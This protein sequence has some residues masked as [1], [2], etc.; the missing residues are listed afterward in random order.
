MESGRIDEDDPQRVP[1]IHFYLFHKTSQ[2]KMYTYL[3]S[4]AITLA[5][6]P[7]KKEHANSYTEEQDLTKK[8]ALFTAQG[9]HRGLGWQKICNVAGKG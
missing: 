3:Q 4:L 2:A 9:W 1:T 7:Q 6:D 5:V 8:H